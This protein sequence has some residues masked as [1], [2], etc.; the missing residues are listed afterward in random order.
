LPGGR[1][2]RQAL[3]AVLLGSATLAAL[4][5][6][7][8]DYGYALDEATYRWVAQEARAWSA[9]FVKN[10]LGDSIRPFTIQ[11]RCHFL[12][13]PGSRPNQPHS[14]FNLPASIHV[15]NAGWAIGGWRA[16][17]LSRL[18]FGSELL[19][20]LTIGGV[21][22]R[23]SARE[24]LLPAAGAA[25]GIVLCP[26]VF[27]HAHLAAT[28]TT[29]VCFWI[30][31][32]IA[33]VEVVERRG[34]VAAAAIAL[35]LLAATKLTAWPACA[36]MVAW[37]AW[38]AKDRR[39]R[40]IFWLVVGAAAVVYVL[41]PN[42]W[43]EP[44]SGLRRYL[45]Q[46]AANP[47]KI[48]AYFG[49][50]ATTEGMSR[51]SGALTLLATT[52]GTVWLL[53]AAALP[54]A[55][56]DRLAQLLWLNLG[57]LLAMR[58]GGL[59]PAHDGER[60]FLPVLAMMGLLAGLQGGR[61]VRRIARSRPILAAL[62][63]AVFLLEPAGESWVYRGHGL[64]YYS[65]AVGGLH[66]AAETFGFEVSYWFE[67]MTDA[68]WRRFLEPLPPGSRVFLRPDHPGWPELVQWG[69]IPEHVSPA[70][71]PEQADYYLLY[72][73]KAAYWVPSGDG[74]SMVRTDLADMQHSA[75]ALY[76]L[77]F[78]GVRLASLHQRRV[79]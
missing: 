74:K 77:R 15:L 66:G 20:A 41:T 6:T 49:G 13:P 24:G 48:A 64:S 78:Q 47:W 10:P 54:Y 35:G 1:I 60:Q 17:E 33:V 25:F 31:A 44:V 9:A 59:V 51:W 4:L 27:G 46:A 7:E 61:L 63:S 68:E 3:A 73:K 37:S 62:A 39:R 67:A 34:S 56:L 79:P 55:R 16:S 21:V 40:L 5:W 42:L 75:P 38:H 29:L 72:A 22:W 14:N 11:Q 58:I 32:I 52:P 70:S 19:F 28:E 43:N 69:V 57:L 12:E 30:W 8:P 76:E 18:R 2:F 26:R 45:T 65:R 23:L 71:A 53:A 36:M 50:Q